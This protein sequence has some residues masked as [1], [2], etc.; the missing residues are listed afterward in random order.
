MAQKDGPG[1]RVDIGFNGGQVLTVR[2][3]TKALEELRGALS[4][5][6]WH[7]LASADGEVTLDLGQV[8]YV[9]AEAEEHSI[10]FSG[11]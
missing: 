1:Q 7:Q 6:G 2:L 10:G 9:K 8:A 11:E 4:K 3:S 5:G